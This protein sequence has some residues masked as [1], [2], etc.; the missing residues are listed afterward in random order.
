MIPSIG[1]PDHGGSDYRDQESPGR[2]PSS[3]LNSRGGCG[4]WA[5]SSSF[6]VEHAPASPPPF[7]ANS[8]VIGLRHHIS[9]GA[10]VDILQ[11]FTCGGSVCEGLT[12]VAIR[13]R[14]GAFRLSSVGRSGELRKH[15][16]G[17][18]TGEKNRLDRAA[19]LPRTAPGASS[20]SSRMPEGTLRS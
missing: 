5:L 14:L 6:L 12:Q 17:R 20:P 2:T 10:S 16:T 19:D 9:G 13:G 15:E 3:A 11:A 1:I 4:W 8:P 18:S 7:S